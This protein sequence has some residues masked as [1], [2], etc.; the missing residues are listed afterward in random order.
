MTL[1]KGP[2][3]RCVQYADGIFIAITGP[4]SY[5]FLSSEKAAAIPNSLG[6]AKQIFEWEEDFSIVKLAFPE[7]FTTCEMYEAELD[8]LAFHP[9]LYETYFGV[10]L[11]AGQSYSR[12]RQVALRDATAFDFMVISGSR[13]PEKWPDHTLCQ[14]MSCD[15]IN[16]GKANARNEDAVYFLVPTEH[17][18]HIKD[19]QF[20][21][22][23]GRLFARVLHRF[24]PEEVV[25]P[26]R[27]MSCPVEISPS[28]KG[29]ARHA[30]GLGRN[31][32]VSYRNNFV[33]P[34]GTAQHDDWTKLVMAGYAVKHRERPA[35]FGGSDLFSLSRVG[36]E[37]VLLPGENLGPED[38]P[39]HR[40][41]Q[42]KNAGLSMT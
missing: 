3:T 22:F 23:D 26:L 32:K 12:D 10:L 13:H 40:P 9:D 33:A 1:P 2:L 39:E 7:V 31:H 42:R 17:F 11:A 35:I 18:H 34:K 16:N 41:L 24:T 21:V 5:F 15:D 30:L 28:Q 14:A 4:H 8:L 20:S 25:I 29:L 38:F 36:A 27:H 37:K 6:G 19:R